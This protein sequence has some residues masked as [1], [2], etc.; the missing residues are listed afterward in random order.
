[1]VSTASVSVV[2]PLFNKGNCIERAIR[3][4]LG[5]TVPCHEILVV[6]DGSTDGGHRVVE[7]IQEHRIKL[8]RQQNQGCSAARNKGIAEA[9]GGLVAFLDADDEWKPWFLEV[10]L[11][12][13]ATYPEAGAYA[14]AYEIQEPDGRVWAPSYREIPAPPWEGIIPNFFRSALG[15]GPVWTSAVAVRRKVLDQVGYF[16]LRPG[17]GQDRELWARIALRYPIAFSWRMGAVYHTEAENRRCQT[18]F[19]HVFASDCFEQ[20]VRSQTVPSHILPDVQEFIACEKLMAASRYV[21]D[22]Q[23]KLARGILENCQTHQFLRRKLW[24]W[25]WSLLP[26]GWVKLAWR[27]KQCFRKYLRL[28]DLRSYPHQ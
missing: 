5:Q 7:R 19:T 13:R 27:S 22:G 25:F 1:M 6:D 14:T 11:N 21:I 8:F 18:V 2:I 17:L 4:V 12:L 9:Q 28:W 10:V 23:S 26:T 3:S 20:A 16:V 24:W 15:Y